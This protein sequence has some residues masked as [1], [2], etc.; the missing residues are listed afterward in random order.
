MTG[1]KLFRIL[2]FVRWV[3]RGS[4]V[5]LVWL[6]LNVAIGRVRGQLACWWSL[7]N[8]AIGRVIFLY[9][10]YGRGAVG[11]RAWEGRGW[12]RALPLTCGYLC[13]LSY[14]TRAAYDKGNSDIY[15]GVV[16][17][18]LSV[19]VVGCISLVPLYFRGGRSRQLKSMY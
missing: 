2:F 9:V 10:L 11:V 17:A 16:S 8:V 3:R 1:V 4:D 7:L 14:H 13:R 6:L 18:S 19:V 12:G 15:E 5:F